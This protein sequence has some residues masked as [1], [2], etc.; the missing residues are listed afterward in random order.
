MKVEDCKPGTRVIYRPS[1]NDTRSYVG[2]VREE[3][4][5]LGDGCWVTHLK[6]V[7]R[8]EKPYVHAAYVD[9]LELAEE[10]GQ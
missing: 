6:D 2:T 5:K 3:P 7:N 9:M 10:E 8:P 1:R 4:W